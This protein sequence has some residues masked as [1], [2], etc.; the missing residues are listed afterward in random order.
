MQ[1]RKWDLF[2]EQSYLNALKF[3]KNINRSETEKKKRSYLF[4]RVLKNMKHSFSTI[5]FY[6]L[7]PF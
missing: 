3:M 7:W 1:F 4:F 5:E 6:E 2:V